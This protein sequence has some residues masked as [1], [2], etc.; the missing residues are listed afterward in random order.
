MVYLLVD[1]CF[2]PSLRYDLRIWTFGQRNTR[3][4]LCLVF[5]FVCVKEFYIIM[6]EM[7][8]EQTCGH[9]RGSTI[10][11]SA[12]HLK[13]IYPSYCFSCC[14]QLLY[15]FLPARCF[16]VALTFFFF[17]RSLSVALYKVGISG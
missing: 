16:L 14:I 17:L 4:G 13:Q 1:F 15:I 3:N 2:S 5:L 6:K 11:R 8:N 7:P 9:P 10:D 12:V